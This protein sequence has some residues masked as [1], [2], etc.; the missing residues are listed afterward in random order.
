MRFALSMTQ[1]NGKQVYSCDMNIYAF[2]FTLI[3][4]V[5]LDRSQ[6]AHDESVQC[7][8]KISN[9]KDS[10]LLSKAKDSVVLSDAEMI[11]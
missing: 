1:I 8:S 4:L 2:D 9:P 7:C 10:V 6:S 5:F 3:T 11:G